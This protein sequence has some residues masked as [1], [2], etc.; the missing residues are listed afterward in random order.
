MVKESRLHQ[1]DFQ[2]NHLV[3]VHLA[4]LVFLDSWIPFLDDAQNQMEM[5][6]QG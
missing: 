3:W 4:F 6:T 1:L 2:V 5:G